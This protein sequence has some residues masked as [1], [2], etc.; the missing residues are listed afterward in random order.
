MNQ[1]KEFKITGKYDETYIKE[2]LAL[3]KFTSKENIRSLKTYLICC[4]LYLFFCGLFILRGKSIPLFVS[5]LGLA[6]LLV[7][8]IQCLNIYQSK[9]KTKR[10]VLAQINKYK[11]NLNSIRE[12]TFNEYCVKYHDSEIVF[13]LKWEAISY[14]EEYENY[15][16][17][18]LKENKK[19]VL[20]LDKN[21]IPKSCESNLFIFI[22]SKIS[23][24]D[25]N[26]R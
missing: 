18:F 9:L 13:E 15:L 6:T 24:K 17:F 12:I 26:S 7:L 2:C 20:G 11:N 19:P 14:Y 23:V 22:N 1:E 8:I 16:F 25:K 21:N 5:S 10:S 4:F 3:W